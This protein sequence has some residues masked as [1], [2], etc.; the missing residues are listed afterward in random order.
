[1]P[2]SSWPTGP[3]WKWAVFMEGISIWNLGPLDLSLGWPPPASTVWLTGHFWVAQVKATHVNKFPRYYQTLYLAMLLGSYFKPTVSFIFQAVNC[4]TWVFYAL[5][6]FF[7]RK[8]EQG[9]G[10]WKKDC[11]IFHQFLASVPSTALGSPTICRCH[12]FASI[13]PIEKDPSSE[14]DKLGSE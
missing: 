8:A 3:F 10:V 6:V 4:D 14:V 7:P 5:E 11:T 9:T 12:H 13:A 2:C 1:M